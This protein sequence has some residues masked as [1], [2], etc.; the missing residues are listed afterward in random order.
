VSKLGQ[1]V[2]LVHKLRK[3]AGTEEL[4][5]RCGYRAHVDKVLRHRRSEVRRRRHALAR[6]S[7][8]AQQSDAD[9]VLEQFADRAHAAVAKVVDVI[10]MLFAVAQTDEPFNDG[11]DINDRQQTFL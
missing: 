3:L 2:C 5:Q 11:D 10:H 9:L 8:H 6:D 7:L 1:R 4:A